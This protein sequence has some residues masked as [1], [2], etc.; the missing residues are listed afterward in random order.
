MRRPKPRGIDSLGSVA[1]ALDTLPVSRTEPI[2]RR[3]WNNG[4][5]AAAAADGMGSVP[6]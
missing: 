5:I 1:L 4:P 2:D 6:I 3:F